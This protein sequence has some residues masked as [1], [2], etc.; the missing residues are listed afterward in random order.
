M[1]G[2]WD[3]ARQLEI[4]SGLAM[5]SIKWK[6]LLFTTEAPQWTDEICFEWDLKIGG[7]LCSRVKNIGS[8]RAERGCDERAYAWNFELISSA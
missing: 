5:L 3:I 8:N 4:Y 1:S 7:D 2:I 6:Y